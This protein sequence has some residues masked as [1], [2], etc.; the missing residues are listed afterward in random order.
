MFDASCFKII[1]Y[2]M[3]RIITHQKSNKIKEVSITTCPQSSRGLIYFC[4]KYE[5]LVQCTSTWKKRRLL[6][7]LFQA[8]LL[9]KGYLGLY[10]HNESEKGAKYKRKWQAISLSTDFL[11]SLIKSQLE[12]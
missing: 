11:I 12:N 7:S 9:L 4:L 1:K 10:N 6:M 2:N 3:S 8:L 5:G